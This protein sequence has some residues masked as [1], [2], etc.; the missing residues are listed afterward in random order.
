MTEFPEGLN[1]WK[2]NLTYER[3]LNKEENLK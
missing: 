3:V 1:L 2:I